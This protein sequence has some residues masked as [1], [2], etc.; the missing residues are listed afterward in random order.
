MTV[1]SMSEGQA[2]KPMESSYAEWH[3]RQE[4]F[5]LFAAGRH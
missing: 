1:L 4:S 5:D 3:D 2:H